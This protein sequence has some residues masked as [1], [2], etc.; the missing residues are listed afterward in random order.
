[1]AR[2]T[3]PII[4]SLMLALGQMAA[5]R[6]DA[7]GQMSLGELAATL[8]GFEPDARVEFSAG[9]NPGEF[10]SYRGYYEF[11]ALGSQDGPCAVAELLNQ[12]EEAIGHTFEGYKGGDFLM[13][14]RTPVWVSE[15]GYDS[16]LGIV[17]TELQD[18]GV[19]V[20]V[21]RRIEED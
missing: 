3:D 18:S 6:C 16:G 1:M 11:V 8:R 7:A 10:H 19:V 20:L 4:D 13:T 14:R 5:A 9:G 2:S 15:Y 17:G 12:T 21:V